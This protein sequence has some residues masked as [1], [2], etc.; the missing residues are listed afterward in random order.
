MYIVET[1]NYDASVIFMLAEFLNLVGTPK[2]MFIF[3]AR[4]WTVIFT[5]QYSFLV[6]FRPLI[7]NLSA[8]LECY[9]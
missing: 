9:Y 8:W 7:Q 6:F 3:F 1:V 2:W 4:G 5:I